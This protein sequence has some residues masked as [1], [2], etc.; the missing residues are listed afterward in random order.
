M[1]SIIHIVYGTVEVLRTCNSVAVLLFVH[2]FGTIASSLNVSG[3]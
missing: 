3:A 2:C 1:V